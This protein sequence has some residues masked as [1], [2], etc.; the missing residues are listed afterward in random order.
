MLGAKEQ[1][2][3]IIQLLTTVTAER[4]V[5]E[6][7][8]DYHTA[9]LPA[10]DHICQLQGQRGNVVGD[11]IAQAMLF[12]ERQISLMMQDTLRKGRSVIYIF[13][14]LLNDSSRNTEM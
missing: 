10:M 13:C 3:A 7:V 2:D 8:K 12:Q 5:A 9:I 1:R 4:M 6:E 14:Y 11:H